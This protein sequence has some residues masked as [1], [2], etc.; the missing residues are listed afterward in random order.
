M[1]DYNKAM[2]LV[3]KEANKPIDELTDKDLLNYRRRHGRNGNWFGIKWELQ[4]IR[5]AMFAKEDFREK[6]SDRAM[7]SYC[8]THPELCLCYELSPEEEMRYRL[9]PKCREIERPEV[10]EYG[11]TK[12]ELNDKR[13]SIAK[14]KYRQ[15]YYEIY[16]KSF[17]EGVDKY[18]SDGL[19]EIE[20]SIDNDEVVAYLHIVKS[21]DSLNKISQEMHNELFDLREQSM[22]KAIPIK[23]QRIYSD[24]ALA[25]QMLYHAASL[26]DMEFYWLK[27][28]REPQT[29]DFSEYWEKTF[30]KLASAK[31]HL[32]KAGALYPDEFEKVWPKCQETYDLKLYVINLG[33]MYD[34]KD[35][36]KLRNICDKY[37]IDT[38]KYSDADLWFRYI[39]MD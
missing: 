14:F 7:M 32:D 13:K 15:K 23:A 24:L 1:G 22:R 28:V 30:L 35:I 8:E 20:E 17:I 11:F 31:Y 2:K 16:E 5:A 34:Y 29:W 33:G 3:S 39:I 21:T 36:V 10:D 37:K 26:I 6:V 9:R 27:T 12:Q 4:N 18:D 38:S 25:F 19:K